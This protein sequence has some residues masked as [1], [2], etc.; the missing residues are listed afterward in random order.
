MK[1]WVKYGLHVRLVEIQDARF[2]LDLRTDPRLSR[3]MTGTSLSVQDQEEW[4][5]RY[6]E[7]ER[8]GEEYYFITL[9]DQGERLG[10]SR[11]Y[12][13]DAESFEAGSWIYR[14]G[15]DTSVPILGDLAVRDFGFDEL[16]YGVCRFEVMK[17]NE[18][19]I[20]YHR[21]FQPEFLGEDERACYFRITR[22]AYETYRDKLLKIFY[23]G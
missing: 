18:S 15:L 5:A 2:I 23:H 8:R 7:R 16:R 4:I 22:E 9:N 13:F 11:L 10:V 20:R 12:N 21:R 3:Y 1:Q 14:W 6:K 19:V 17:G